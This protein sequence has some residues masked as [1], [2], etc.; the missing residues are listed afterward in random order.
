MSEYRDDRGR[1]RPRTV[2]DLGAEH[3]QLIAGLVGRKHDPL[4]HSEDPSLSS[5]ALA[6]SMVGLPTV[7]DGAKLPPSTLQ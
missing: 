1:Y 3:A 7:G 5:Q 4:S 2:D 6:R